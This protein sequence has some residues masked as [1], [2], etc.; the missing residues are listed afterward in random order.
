MYSRV[1][2]PN[3]V[4]HKYMPIYHGRKAR[5]RNDKSRFIITEDEE[6]VLF[7]LADEHEVAPNNGQFDLSSG[8]DYKWLND[9]C[10]GLYAVKQVVVNNQAQLGVIGENG[11]RFAFF[12]SVV[13]KTDAWH[14]YPV[15]A[16]NQDRPLGH[17]LMEYLKCIGYLSSIDIV[18]IKRRA[19]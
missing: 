8:L 16:S 18:R 3:K 4:G 11:E 6:F 1:K 14:G 10:T 2:G 13:N 17:N 9:D 5:K 19:L 12:P 15:M 7:N